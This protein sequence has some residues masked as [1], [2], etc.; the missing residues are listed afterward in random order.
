MKCSIQSPLYLVQYADDTLIFE[1][2]KDIVTGVDYLQ[3]GIKKLF[4]TVAIHRLK[5]IAVK[6]VHCFL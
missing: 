2:A 3:K 4:D 1:A 5:I 6:T